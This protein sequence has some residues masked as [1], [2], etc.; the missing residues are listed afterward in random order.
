MTFWEVLTI[1]PAALAALVI[2]VGTFAGIA[3]VL[4]G[5][6]IISTLLRN[7]RTDKKF[8]FWESIAESLLES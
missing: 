5:R 3:L 1:L 8:Q 4:N 7:Y 6:K 2:I